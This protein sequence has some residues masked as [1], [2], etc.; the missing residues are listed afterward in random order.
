MNKTEPTRRCKTCKQDLTYDKFTPYHLKVS[1]YD[2]RCIECVSRQNSNWYYKNREHAKSY[3][4]KYRA[5]AKDDAFKAYGGFKC[6]C[7]G[8]AE[9]LFLDIDH[10][11]NNG[12]DHRREHNLNSGAQF[13]VWLRHNN[14]PS[15]F[16]VLCCNCNRGKFR[17]NGVCPHQQINSNS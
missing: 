2:G 5:Q 3:M 13:Y 15:N 7:C 8:E 16:Q 6:A 14:Y 11:D 12:A 9:S 4:R 17:N 10:M 1:P